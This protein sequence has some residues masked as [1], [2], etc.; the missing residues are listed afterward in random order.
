MRDGLRRACN[1]PVSCLHDS[2]GLLRL[3]LNQP[4]LQPGQPRR[5]PHPSLALRLL[6]ESCQTVVSAERAEP[7]SAVRA[8]ASTLPTSAKEAGPGASFAEVGNVEAGTY[9]LCKACLSGMPASPVA[10]RQPASTAAATSQSLPFP[11]DGPSAQQPASAETD[12]LM[13]NR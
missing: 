12:D 6:H 7:G 9:C 10:E 11:P 1:S 5:L 2:V 4:P 3:N 13:P 8:V